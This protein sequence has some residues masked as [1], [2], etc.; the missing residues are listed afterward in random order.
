MK[1]P[2]SINLNN[3]VV[4]ITGAGGVICGCLAKA[5]ASNGAKVALLDLNLEAAEAV[6]NEIVAE[7]GVAKAYKTNVLDEEVLKPSVKKLKRIWASPT[8]SSTAQAEI[9]L[10]PPR[11]MNTAPLKSKWT[12]TFLTL[13][14]AG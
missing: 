1:T 8:S 4:V 9:T 6:A 3:K 13:T 14:Q 12:R 7:G 10:V 2:I 11:T 5:L